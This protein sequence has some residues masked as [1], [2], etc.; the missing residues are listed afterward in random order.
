MSIDQKPFLG[1]LP[2]NLHPSCDGL[3]ANYVMNE[4]GGGTVHDYSGNSYDL[5]TFNGDVS[6][7]PG[8][9][10]PSLAFGGV[11]DY[12]TG[13]SGILDNWNGHGAATDEL[14][15][16]VWVMTNN[17]G[18][19]QFIFRLGETG[20]MIND[21]I[22]GWRW[23]PDVDGGAPTVAPY[24][25]ENGVWY[26]VAVVHRNTST[27]TGDHWLYVNGVLIQNASSTDLDLLS[28]TNVI[29][30]ALN[31]SGT[32]DLDGAVSSAKVYNRALSESEVQRD[33]QY[34]FAAYRPEPII[35]TSGAAPPAG[36]QAVFWNH[37][38]K[39]IGA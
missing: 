15:I 1:K 4:S 12:V 31:T 29:V 14:S 26:H 9:H 27:T 28:T 24:T 21:S 33:Y 36:N 7:G 20:L 39:N 38:N 18:L 32:W 37:Y 13:G 35:I 2:R 34:P 23:F 3:V 5:D 30:G 16:A 6:W 8:V 25:I 11:T 22:D 19:D 10:G 17:S